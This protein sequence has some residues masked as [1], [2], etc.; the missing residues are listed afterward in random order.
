M[1]SDSTQPSIVGVGELILDHICS[2]GHNDSD[3]TLRESRGGGS[4]FNV[5]ANLSRLGWRTAAHGVVGDDQSGAVAL[6]DLD[7]LGVETHAV[8]SIAGKRTRLIFELLGVREGA[9]VGG[10]RHSFTTKCPVC[11]QRIETS[12]R[13]TLKVDAIRTPSAA[14]W[15][16]Y[17]QLTAGRIEHV[18]HAR[19]SGAR[20]VLD[21]GAVGYLR[22]QPTARILSQLRQ[23]DLIFLNSK[24]AASLAKRANVKEADLSNLLPSSVLVITRGAFGA[25]VTDSHGFRARIA[26]PEVSRVYDDAGAGDALCA[27]TLNNLHGATGERE[28]LASDVAF[29]VAQAEDEITEV[30]GAIG[31]RGHLAAGPSDHVFERLYGRDFAQLREESAASGRCLL[32]HLPYERGV[33]EVNPF[34]IEVL[35]ESTDPEPRRPPRKLGARGNVALLFNRM[36]LVADNDAATRKARE[37]LH[38]D[39]LTTLVVGSGGSL[40][41]A[42]YIATVLNTFGH[43]AAWMTPGEYLNSPMRP[44]SVIVV[45]YSGSTHDHGRVIE[46]ARR[47]DRTRVV[48]LSGSSSPTLA[49]LLRSMRDDVHIDYSSAARASRHRIGVRERGFVSITGTVAPCV[50][51]LTAATDIHDVVDLVD[52]L[53]SNQ[54]VPKDVAQRLAGPATVTG[55]LH[56]VYGP[57][58]QPAALDVESK[59]VESGLPSV[60][61]HEQKD[62]SHGRF[63]T[64]FQRPSYRTP[65]QADDELLA[66]V[67]LLGMGP[68]S[69]YQQ[70]LQRALTAAKVPNEKIWSE[71]ADLT[72]PLELLTSV[73]LF[74]QEFGTQLGIDI[75][76]PRSIPPGGLRLYKWR[77]PLP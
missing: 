65:S 56:V 67:L 62:L 64:V 44:D 26:A 49:R 47:S 25:T 9:Q 73:Q 17:D 55:R 27:N 33:D 22:Y 71:A 75:S 10:S 46:A 12:Q 20:A 18:Q 21:L 4:V 14:H 53:H 11:A 72:A 1:P 50:P 16:L 63:M 60:S 6:A 35:E 58:G 39:R 28:L 31:A 77:G 41:A 69:K 30:L 57:G 54:T 34:K 45:S 36:L 2:P 59:F 70:A 43:F 7:G 29:A 68:P 40:P 15:A 5:L 13:P 24:V 76:R 8:R 51:W 3:G 23:F 42:A 61:L 48:L 52:R 66:P 74:S 19:E 32:C 37:V 38:G